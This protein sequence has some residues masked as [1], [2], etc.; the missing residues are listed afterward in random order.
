MYSTY[1]RM[2]TEKS[3]KKSALFKSKLNS[4]CF[5]SISTAAERHRRSDKCDV[6]LDSLGSA[7]RTYLEW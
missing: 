4:V 7:P 3:V 5:S 1:K 2:N 6:S